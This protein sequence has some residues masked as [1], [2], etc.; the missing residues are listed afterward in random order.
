[1]LKNEDR[2]QSHTMEL[3]RLIEIGE[4]NIV[5]FGKF[6][7]SLNKQKQVSLICGSNVPKVLK[8]KVE[9]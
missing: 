6:L 9:K 5:D 1:M 8:I 2:M 7:K 4:K 3:P